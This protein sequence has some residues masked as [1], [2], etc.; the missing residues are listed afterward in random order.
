MAGP[1]PPS[2]SEE[3]QGV[4]SRA[5][6]S[7][8]SRKRWRVYCGAQATRGT[9]VGGRHFGPKTARSLT[10]AWRMR[11]FTTGS[12]DPGGHEVSEVGLRALCAADN[13]D[14]AK[15]CS[16]AVFLSCPKRASQARPKL[17]ARR[18]PLLHLRR[19]CREAV[20]TRESIGSSG[21]RAVNRLQ[22]SV[23]SIFPPLPRRSYARFAQGRRGRVG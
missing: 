15:R 11:S 9:P 20:S 4:G 12:S 22:R 14:T 19:E 13:A 2:A 16:G 21:A 10:G 7:T 3:D 17:E 23:R 1:T 18:Q 6:R 8:T 5:G